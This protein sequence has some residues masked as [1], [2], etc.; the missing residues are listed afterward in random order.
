M[1]VKMGM[2][3]FL[4]N[5]KK[6]VTLL[7]FNADWCAPCKAQEKILD[8]LTKEYQGQA[9]FREM[10][11]DEQKEI[12]TKFMVQSIPTLIIFRNGKEVGRLIGLQSKSAISKVLDLAL[13]KSNNRKPEKKP[14]V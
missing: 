6:G 13:E 3:R 5:I 10:N 4:K 1:E 8:S 14:E 9:S 11:I 2:D 7:D 12:A